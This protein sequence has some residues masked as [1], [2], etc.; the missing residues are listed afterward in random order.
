M[1]PISSGGEETDP[2]QAGQPRALGETPPLLSPIPSDP[3][4]LREEFRALRQREREIIA[5]LG[6]S[7]SQ[8]ILHDIRNLLNE[9]HLLRYLADKSD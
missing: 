3:N 7:S 4:E 9:V 2:K 5:L 8:R 6:S 1:S